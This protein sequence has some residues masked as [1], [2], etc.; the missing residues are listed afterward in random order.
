MHYI[1]GKTKI[2]LHM[3]NKPSSA[4]SPTRIEKIMTAAN[5]P[6]VNPLKNKHK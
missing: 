4:T 2:Y 1:K 6:F 3:A 5:L